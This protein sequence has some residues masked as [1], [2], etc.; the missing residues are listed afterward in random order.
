VADVTKV[1]YLHLV[2]CHF[3]EINFPEFNFSIYQKK[4]PSCDF[5]LSR[6]ILIYKHESH[7]VNLNQITVS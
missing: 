1:G 6:K 4:I 7:L 3:A 2:L 5:E